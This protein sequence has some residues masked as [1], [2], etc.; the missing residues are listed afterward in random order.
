MLKI[1]IV[2]NIECYQLNHKYTFR[3]SIA[4]KGGLWGP[5]LSH[6]GVSPKYIVM[7]FGYSRNF[8][9]TTKIEC[10]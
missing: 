5:R 8:S 7:K 9:S 4:K 6:G 3:K 1:I 2:I 10:V